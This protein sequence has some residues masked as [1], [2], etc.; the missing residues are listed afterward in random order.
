MYR[1]HYYEGEEKKYIIVTQFEEREARKV[2]P[3]LDRPSLKA[4]FRIEMKIPQ[5][6]T[7][8][9]N[10]PIQSESDPENGLKTV[11]FEETPPLCTYT[12]FFG[13]GQFEFL[14]SETKDALIRVAGP[15]GRIQF[16]EFA[17][18]VAQKSL[19][20]MVEYTGGLCSSDNR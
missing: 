13:I 8:I 1:S 12:L 19:E 9:S 11:W 6:M 2:F 18:S 5:N 14:E 4:P 17:L 7:A 16:G 3:C 15:P 20:A 10:T